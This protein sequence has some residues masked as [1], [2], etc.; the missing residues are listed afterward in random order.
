MNT[1]L[2]V[3]SAKVSAVSKANFKAMVVNL[4]DNVGQLVGKRSMSY[5]ELAEWL[6]EKI[7]R[8]VNKDELWRTATGNYQ[9]EPSWS[10]LAALATVDEFVFLGTPEP[11]TL[12]G[13]HP[14][15]D[16]INLVL[17]GQINAYGSALTD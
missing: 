2:I 5:V 7:G 9:T 17:L 12:K 3:D 4:K 1:E 13:I 8:P 14:T 15:Q 10:V 6:T 16:Q 11:G